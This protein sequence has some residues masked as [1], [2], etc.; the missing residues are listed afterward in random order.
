MPVTGLAR[1]IASAASRRE[2]LKLG[3]VAGVAALGAPLGQ[4]SPRVAGGVILTDN[5]ATVTLANG[6]ITATVMK[7]NAKVTALLYKGYQMVNT[8]SNG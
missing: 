8:A 1:L 6:I 5:G 4:P 3:S 2:F 7:T